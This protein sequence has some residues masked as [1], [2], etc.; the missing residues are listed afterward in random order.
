MTDTLISI[1]II[2]GANLFAK[3]AIPAQISTIATNIMVFEETK[4][5]KKLEAIFVEGAG[6]S[7]K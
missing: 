4:A 1:T 2:N 3:S 6:G 7:I 5:L